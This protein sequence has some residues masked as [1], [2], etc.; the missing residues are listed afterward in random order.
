VT[1]CLG[2]GVVR[3]EGFEPP[4]LSS[5]EPKSRASTSSATPASTTADLRCGRAARLISWPKH[6]AH[7]KNRRGREPSQLRIFDPRRLPRHRCSING[8]LRPDIPVRSGEGLRLPLISA[9]PRKPLGWILRSLARRPS[10]FAFVADNSGKWLMENR[11]LEHPD[12]GMVIW[13]AVG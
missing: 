10:V 2:C 11:A 6:A 3:A 13:F 4:R 1:R 12:T 8:S 9:T 5:R 7:D